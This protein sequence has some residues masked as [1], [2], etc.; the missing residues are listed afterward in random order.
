MNIYGRAD[1]AAAILRQ[2][3][4]ALALGLS[5]LEDLR[6]RVLEAERRAQPDS[7]SSSRPR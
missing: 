6:A 2:R 7:S 3:L 5:E 4:E 1:D